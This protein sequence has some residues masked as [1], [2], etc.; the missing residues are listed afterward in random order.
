MPGIVHYPWRVNRNVASGVLGSPEGGV[1]SP[2]LGAYEVGDDGEA[3]E[4]PGPSM[5]EGV[6]QNWYR[7]K[8]SGSKV[9]YSAEYSHQFQAEDTDSFVRRLH[10]AL[11][12][13]FVWLS[14]F[15]YR[16]RDDTGA[17]LADRKLSAAC[18]SFKKYLGSEK[19]FAP[20][21]LIVE[22]ARSVPLVIASIIAGPRKVL[23][24]KHVNVPIDKVQDLDVISLIDLARRPGKTVA[25]KAGPKQ[26]IM[27]LTRRETPDT[28]ENRVVL[29]FVRRSGFAARQYKDE[30]C[31]RC[32]RRESCTLKDPVV[33]E[34]CPS[35]RVKV[36]AN[37]ARQCR[38]WEQ[39]DSFAG[40]LRMKEPRTRPNYVLQQNVRYIKIWKYYLRLLRLE[41]VE[42]DVWRWMR[43][44]WAD[45]VKM[46]FLLVWEERL[47]PL[48]AL[49]TSARPFMIRAENV[50]GKWLVANL[51]EDAL[52]FRNDSGCKTLYV[53][54][55]DNAARLVGDNHLSSLNA[56]FII[57]V[58]D[59]FGRFNVRPV[60]AF[61]MDKKLEAVGADS[62]AHAVS[63]ELA[64]LGLDSLAFFPAKENVFVRSAHA[65]CYGV[66]VFSSGFEKVLDE[67]DALVQEMLV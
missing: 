16:Y 39:D 19:D 37:Y 9:L 21:S 30:M 1:V 22:I 40:V 11:T 58:T 20:E 50:Q 8:E 36:V 15:L 7:V 31:A 57:V 29:D 13:A 12:D 64:G 14:G 4:L 33:E 51:F 24:R 63:G 65:C 56:D 54:D 49:Q 35:E 45:M 32:P 48:A 10:F 44:T 61:C 62:L 34:R 26:R 47:K 55:G 43:S 42:E 17:P 18:V 67:I 60:W 27:A 23:M 66:N 41:N 3:H 53:L 28:I 6:G 5:H 38:G 59:E 25:M 2:E 46:L 52:V